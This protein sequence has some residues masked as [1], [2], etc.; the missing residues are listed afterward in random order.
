[1]TLL[2]VPANSNYLVQRHMHCTMKS[3]STT[4]K[5]N[6]SILRNYHEFQIYLIR[7]LNILDEPATQ[8]QV[9]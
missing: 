4:I 5:E 6:A 1:M 7:Y 9:W 2:R 3:A 8:P